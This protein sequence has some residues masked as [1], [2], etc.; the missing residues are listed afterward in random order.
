MLKIA[1]PNKGSLADASIE[2]LKEAGY[3]QRVDTRDL[4]LSVCSSCLSRAVGRYGIPV[5]HR[6]I[7]PA[8]GIG[9]GRA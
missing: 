6:V 2:I 9:E 1:V 3:R 7:I 8:L 5:A 4:V